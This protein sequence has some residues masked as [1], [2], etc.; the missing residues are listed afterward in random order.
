MP[1]TVDDFLELYARSAAAHRAACAQRTPGD[2]YNGEG[3]R[4]RF[5]AARYGWRPARL[6]SCPRWIVGKH[7]QQRQS[8]ICQRHRN[9]LDHNRAWLD[10]D[11]KRV[12]TSE[13]YGIGDTLGLCAFVQECDELG[14]HVEIDPQSPWFPGATVLLIMRRAGELQAHYREQWREKGA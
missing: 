5:F 2:P 3:E 1:V 14:V 12:L 7:C 8:C 13:P 9:V 11:G 10:R 6:R 4:E